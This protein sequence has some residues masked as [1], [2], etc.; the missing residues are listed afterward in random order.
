MPADPPDRDLTQ[1]ETEAYW[2]KD[3]TGLIKCDGKHQA[4]VKFIEDRDRRIGGD[5]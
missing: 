1:E 4:L 5:K 3:T 2:G